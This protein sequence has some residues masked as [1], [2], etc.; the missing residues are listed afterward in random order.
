MHYV[1]ESE[2]RGGRWPGIGAREIDGGKEQR[3]GGIIT[4]VVTM[5][6]KEAESEQE[7]QPGAQW[8]EGGKGGGLY[9]GVIGQEQ[10][11]FK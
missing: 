4:S 5:D 8:E 10:H 3:R 2:E 7:G 11:T 9:R 6:E 1:E